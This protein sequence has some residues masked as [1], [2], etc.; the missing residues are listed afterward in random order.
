MLTQ[1]NSSIQSFYVKI[2][3]ILF[4]SITM[5][6][7]ILFACICMCVLCNI[8][9]TFQETKY[10]DK[11]QSFT[12]PN[13]FIDSHINIWDSPRFIKIQK[14]CLAILT[15]GRLN[16]K[17]LLS[18]FILLW[19]LTIQMIL[20]ILSSHIHNGEFALQQMPHL[21]LH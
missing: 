16:N 13:T 20:H 2:F 5:E 14:V 19:L 1:T 3:S 11:Y 6:S 17:Q 18:L 7:V 10:N 8:E 9:D 4:V 12:K 15:I 21:S